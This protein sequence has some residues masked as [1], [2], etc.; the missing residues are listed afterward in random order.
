MR[1]ISANYVFPVSVPPVRN[2]VIVLD[3]QDRI[4]EIVDPGSHF[5]ET[6]GLEYYNGVLVP[7]FIVFVEYARRDSVENTIESVFYMLAG[8]FKRAGCKII[9]LSFSGKRFL[10]DITV[11]T[12]REVT[13]EYPFPNPV[14]I[15]DEDS[16]ISLF[17]FFPPATGGTGKLSPMELFVRQ[18]KRITLDAAT[19]AGL[20]RETGSLDIGKKPGVQLISPYDFE[21]WRPAKNA[22]IQTLVR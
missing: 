18:L 10:L 9:V 12:I 16:I 22:Q 17:D 2:G 11:E 4:T 13:P 3:D 7:S 5:R 14:F 21:Q 8:P 1:K 6:A 20:Q 19:L 15:I